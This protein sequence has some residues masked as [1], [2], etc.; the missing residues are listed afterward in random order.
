MPKIGE[1]EFNLDALLLARE[2]DRWMKCIDMNF[3]AHKEKD[4]KIMASYTY[5]WIG[6]K[7]RDD[8][9]YLIWK[10]GEV[11]TSGKTLMK[12]RK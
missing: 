10:E 2:Y 5:A 11:W 7:G 4:D 6:Q 8:L 1:P 9:A 3:N 12:K